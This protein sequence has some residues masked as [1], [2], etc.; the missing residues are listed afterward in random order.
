[1][2]LFLKVIMLNSKIDYVKITLLEHSL[3]VEGLIWTKWD[4]PVDILNRDLF[5]AQSMELTF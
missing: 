4:E 5:K 2:E 1:L 3:T